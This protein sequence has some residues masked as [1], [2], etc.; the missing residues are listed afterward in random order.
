MDEAAFE[1]YLN[2][3]YNDQ[4]NW[5]DQKAM[6]YR[7]WSQTWRATLIA[8]SALTPVVLVSHFLEPTQGWLAWVAL[9]SAVVNLAATG[10]MKTFQ[11]E[12]HWQRYRNT[13]EDLRS[14]IHFYR[15]SAREYRDAQ[16]K[17]AIFVHRV[18]EIIGRERKAWQEVR[19]HREPMPAGH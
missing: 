12:E 5:Y 7:R 15:A 6:R 17:Q 3:R 9:G 19:D 2:D 18:E 10:T 1:K 16:D 14:E 4:V 13:C 8:T 11:F